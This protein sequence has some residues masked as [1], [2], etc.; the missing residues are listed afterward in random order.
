MQMIADK[1][2]RIF[3][4]GLVAG[5]KGGTFPDPFIGQM[6]RNKDEAKVHAA[7]ASAPN[8]SSGPSAAG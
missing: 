1:N 4:S 5:K 8:D 7:A 3:P 6:A 2:G